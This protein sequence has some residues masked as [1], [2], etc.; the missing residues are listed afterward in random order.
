MERLFISNTAAFPLLLMRRSRNKKIKACFY[1][2]TLASPNR[3]LR[4]FSFSA[5][6]AS[7]LSPAGDNIARFL[8]LRHGDWGYVRGSA[9]KTPA[10]NFTV[11]NRRA[12]PCRAHRSFRTAPSGRCFG[13]RPR[14]PLALCTF[15]FYSK[16][17]GR[18]SF[19]SKIRF[20]RDTQFRRGRIPSRRRAH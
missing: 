16:A 17:C 10:G 11:L 6:L 18:A 20:P 8:A 14:S 4:E 3:N 5:G 9:P 15:H 19:Y 7:S 13:H 12:S 2:K 1:S